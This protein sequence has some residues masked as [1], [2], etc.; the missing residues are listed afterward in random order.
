MSNTAQRVIEKCGGPKVVAEMLNLGLPSV[1][2][3]TYPTEKGG[4]GGHIPSKR[5]SE[6]LRKATAAGIPLTPEDF[7]DTQGNGDD[8]GASGTPSAAK[9][10]CDL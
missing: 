10:S 7:F 5:Q 8:F 3:W 6:L 2:K 4:S 9:E 1:F